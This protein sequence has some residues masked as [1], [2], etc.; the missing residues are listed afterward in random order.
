MSNFEFGEGYEVGQW[1]N[2][3]NVRYWREEEHEVI[4]LAAQTYE[5]NCEVYD[6]S[7]PAM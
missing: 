4:P 7:R 3:I 5:E 1:N 2:V 6:G